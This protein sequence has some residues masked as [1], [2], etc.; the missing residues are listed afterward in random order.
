MQTSLLALEFSNPPPLA[1]DMAALFQPRPGFANPFGD[2]RSPL[3]FYDGAPVN[4][5][6]DWARRRQEILERWHGIMGPWPA[7]IEKPR[8]E[9]RERAEREDFVRCRVKVEVA[10]GQT[11]DGYLLLP[12][13]TGKF[14]AV[15]VPFYDAVTSV[16][17]GKPEARL[18]DFA[19]QLTKRGFVTLAVG[20]PGPDA[21]KPDV[22]GGKCQPLSYLAYVA[23][24]CASALANLPEVD[25]HRLGVVGHSYGAK[26]AMF[27]SCLDERFACAVWS[28]A[29]IVFDETRPNVNY[30]DPWYLGAQDGPPRPLERVR[31]IRAQALPPARG[32]RDGSGACLDGSPGRFSFPEVPKTV[33]NAGR[34]LQPCGGGQPLGI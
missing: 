32:K 4:S 20:S 18:R 12:H 29:G 11:L 30:W 17:L 21:R 24:D 14:P 10:L 8:V 3:K 19:Y 2:F 7:L 33:R 26:W 5:A 15:L 28:D 13:G 1:A 22:P 16:G 27:A 23:A 31:T 25:P 34:A 6:A 9:I